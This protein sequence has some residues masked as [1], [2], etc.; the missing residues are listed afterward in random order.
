MKEDGEV[1]AGPDKSFEGL[2]RD[3][4]K[5]EEESTKPYEMDVS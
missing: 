2:G 4:D 3:V 5:D 1:S